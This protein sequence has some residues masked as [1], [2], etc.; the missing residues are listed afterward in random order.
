MTDQQTLIIYKFDQLF[1]ILNEAKSYLNFE[2]KAVN[3]NKIDDIFTKNNYLIISNEKLNNFENQVVIKQYPINIIK[4]F[5][6]INI[7]FLKLKFNEQNKIQIGNYYLN[8]NSKI[9]SNKTEK[10]KLTEKEAKIIFFL[11]KSLK[12]ITITSLQKEVWGHRLQLD[13][14][15]VETHIYR[16]RKKIEKKFYDKKFISSLKGGY[17]INA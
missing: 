10:L 17:K 2:I 15:T 7:N 4:L 16:L 1:N 3:S 14:H 12:P 8:L 9:L 6:I 13:T 5:E 11:N